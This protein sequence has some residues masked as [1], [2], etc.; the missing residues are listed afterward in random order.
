MWLSHVH[1]FNNSA[2]YAGGGGRLDFYP[3]VKSSDLFPNYCKHTHCKFRNNYAHWGGGTSIFGTYELSENKKDIDF[4]KCHWLQNR[5]V[6]GSALGLLSH[7]PNPAKQIRQPIGKGI[8][9]IKLFSC[10]FKENF[11]I[12]ISYAHEDDRNNV[13]G[14][15]A[16]YSDIAVIIM[17]DVSFNSNNGTALVLDWSN[18]KIIK[19]VTFSNNSGSKGG[20]VALYGRSTIILGENATLNFTN[21]SAELRGG[22]VYAY[23]QGPDLK[24]FDVHILDRSI[25]FFSYINPNTHPENWTARVYF[26]NNIAPPKSGKSI[27]TDTL[28]FCRNYGNVTEALEWKPTF[29]YNYDFMENN[30]DNHDVVTDPIMINTERIEWDASL[31]ELF[32]PKIFLYDEKSHSV[33]GLLKMQLHGV[34][35]PEQISHYVYVSNN[36]SATPLA[37]ETSKNSDHYNLTLSSVFTQIIKYKL[38]NINITKCYGGYVF[39]S[40]KKKC[41]C[42]DRKKMPFGFS[43]CKGDGKT[44]YLKRGYWGTMSEK[45]FFVLPCPP[46]YCKCSTGE[47]TSEALTDECVFVKFNN[48]IEQC[49]IN[50]SGNLCGSCKGKLSVVVGKQDCRDCRNAKLGPLWL[51]LILAGLTVVV[52]AIIYFELDFFSGPLNSWLYTYHIIHLLPY[53]ESYLD[54]FIN[55]VISLTNGTFDISS[56]KCFWSGMDALQKLT[57]EYVTPFY[58]VI[59]LYFFNKL[60]HYFPRLSF[61]NHSFHRALVT[62]AIILYASVLHST[63]SIL[64]PVIIN[65]EYYV[66]VQANLKYFSKE[67]LPYAIPALLILILIVIPFP[68]IIVFN[69]FFTQNFRFMKNFIPLFQVLQSP[70]RPGRSWFASYYIFCRLFMVLVMIFSPDFQYSRVSVYELISVIILMI[71]VL[72]RPYTNENHFFFIVDTV[73]LSL[74]CLINSF[75]NAM[76]INQDAVTVNFF[77]ILIRIATYIPLLYS[78]GLLMRYAYQSWNDYWQNHRANENT[79]LL[80]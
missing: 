44:I 34:E 73:F 3:N 21:N 64:Q 51:I 72:L 25:C 65:D 22:A 8:L 5:A 35:L 37:L 23:S 60:L 63:M 62:I 9:Y 71:F 12:V 1:V 2:N 20:A 41:V 26:Q 57:L 42:L 30:T 56:G 14:T 19:N 46:E 80:Q 24:A 33:N 13:I 11:I 52:L 61:S 32:Y 39:D 27:Y 53:S 16:I 10:I 54:P 38:E 68:F 17:Q 66:Y 48:A 79:G 4:F 58:C 18:V 43:R 78:V 36:K 7:W 74:L 59:F 6:V 76:Q 70:Y 77:R 15:A 28:Q 40:D 31:G 50:R 49:A 29:N 67:H 75:T 69:N 47:N 55:F 45:G